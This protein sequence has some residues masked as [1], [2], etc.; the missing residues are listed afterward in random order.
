[1][2]KIDKNLLKIPN[3]QRHKILEAADKIIKNELAGL[4]VK[5]LKGTQNIH[6]VRV[7]TY[8]LIFTKEGSK[9]KILRISKRDDKT[10]KDF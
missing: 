4:D 1:M 3:A 6:R 5:K 9:I 10:Y 2:D 8:R 7:G